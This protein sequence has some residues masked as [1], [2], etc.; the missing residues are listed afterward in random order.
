MA[1]MDDPGADFA[2]LL[3]DEKLDAVVEAVYL[4]AFADGVFSERERQHFAESLALLTDG[5][6]DEVRL[7]A[8]QA[9]VASK[10]ESRGRAECIESIASRLD[11]ETL[12]HVAFVL[13]LDM[14]AADGGVLPEERRFLEE[15]AAGLGLQR[16]EAG[17]MIADLPTPPGG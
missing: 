3:D 11:S 14:A 12:R 10:L 4:A 1:A 5:R 17:A 9:R 8:V 16:D 6:V 15:L 7:E 13:A 2:R